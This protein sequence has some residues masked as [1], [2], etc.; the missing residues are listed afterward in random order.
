MSKKEPNRAMGARKGPAERDGQ[1]SA[2]IELRQQGSSQDIRS[3]NH[4][5]NSE[6]ELIKMRFFICP[7]RREHSAATST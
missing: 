6:A 2:S 4:S 7:A 1:H 3:A 5:H